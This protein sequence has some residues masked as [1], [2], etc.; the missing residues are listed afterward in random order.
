MPQ[1]RHL[2]PA[3]PSASFSRSPVSSRTGRR[4]FGII[5]FFFGLLAAAASG[6]NLDMRTDYLGYDQDTL[7]MLQARAAAGQILLQPGDTVGLVMKATPNSGTPTG[8][9]GYSTFFIP[10]GTQLMKADYGR[11]VARQIGR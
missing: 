2:V 4:R 6:H 7:N 3:E 9:G 8:A 1:K 5:G 10:V 11:V